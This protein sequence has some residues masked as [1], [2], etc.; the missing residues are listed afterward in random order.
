MSYIVLN[1]VYS[2]LFYAT[3]SLSQYLW[4]PPYI[5][6]VECGVHQG[7]NIIILFQGTSRPTRYTIVVEDK[8]EMSLTDVE[9]ITHFLCHGHQVCF[10]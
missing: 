7:F 5:I 8:P 3:E 2:C 6:A 4:A 1:L 9:H 10:V